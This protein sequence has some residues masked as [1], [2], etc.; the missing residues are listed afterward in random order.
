MALTLVPDTVAAPGYRFRFLGPNPGDECQGCP[1]Q[2]IC[3]GLEPGRAYEVQAVRDVTHPCALHDEGRVRVVEAVE[4]PV[5]TSLETRLLRGTAAVWNPAPCGRP[6]C[7]EYGFCHPIGP[8]AGAHH[9]IV[10]QEGAMA[11]PAGYDLTRVQ[12]RPLAKDAVTG[13]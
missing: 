5:A 9:E 3:F 4:V 8:V 12:I 10:A 6:A 7:R 13:R 1:F 11:C 2:R